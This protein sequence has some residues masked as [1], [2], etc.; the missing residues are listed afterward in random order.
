MADKLR[1]LTP[2]DV[3]YA[4]GDRPTDQKLEGAEIQTRDAFSYLE[5]TIGDAFGEGLLSDP[6]YVSNISRDIGDRSFLNPVLQPNIEIAGYIQDL[7]AG[8]ME[9]EL[10][11]IPI[12]F[13]A[14]IV[15]SSAD[16]SVLPSQ[17]KNSVSLLEVPGDWT[18]SAG[19]T[20]DGI[21][22][23]SR[24]L[25]THSP[26]NGG[27]I[28]I[29]NVTS[30]RGSGFTKGRNN[31]I[32]S[33]AQARVGGA[34]LSVSVSD[35]TNNIY[36][37]QLPIESTAL[38]HA[39]LDSA[40]SLSNTKPGVGGGQQLKLPTWMFS[41]AGLDMSTSDPVSGRGKVF[42]LNSIRIY[43][44]QTKKIVD[45]LLETKASTNVGARETEI[46]CT[47][48]SDVILDDLSGQYILVTSGASLSECI[49]ALQRDLYFHKHM[50]DDMIRGINHADL[51]DL[52]T[53]DV[54]L[55]RS[56]YYG[57]SSIDNNHHSMYLHRGGFDSLDVGA[58]GNIFRGD[59]L[60]GSDSTG[61]A[62]SHENY[63]LDTDSFHLTFGTETNGGRIYFDKI[64]VQNLPE[65]RGNIPQTFS[66]TS[67]VIEGAMDS[68]GLI[69]TTYIDGKLRAGSDV[70][71][72]TDAT[73]DVLIPGDLY[74]HNS[75]IL[76]PR[77]TSG[78]T[79]ETG[80][81]IYSSDENAPIF[82]NGSRW[83]NATSVGYEV[84]LGDGT[85]SHGKYS[86]PDLATFQAAIDDVS[87]NGGGKLKV[88][89]GNYNFGTG[90]ANIPSQVEVEG[91]G[92]LSFISSST[93]TFSFNGGSS[94]SSISQMRI[95]G[96][97]IAISID[98]N[99]HSVN[100]V[101]LENSGTG[102][103]IASSA[104]ETEL[105]SSIRYA[106]I[107]Q[108]IN[109]LSTNISNK[110]AV[111]KTI[112]YQNPFSPIDMVDKASMI[113]KWKRTSGGGT[114]SYV[115]TTN[116]VMG[117]GVFRISGT[118][119]FV[120]E[121]YIPAFPLAGVGGYVGAYT[122]G[123]AGVTIGYQAYDANLSLLS[124][125]GG[126]ILNGGSLTGSWQF[127]QDVS[128]QESGSGANTFPWGTRFIRASVTVNYNSNHVYFDGLTI[129]PLTFSTISLYA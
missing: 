50:G 12:G 9:H 27:S 88:L 126:F 49:G 82:W 91:E 76:S 94:N 63:N 55:D 129:V 25:I 26:S 110:M 66:D 21:Q 48:R 43:D 22:K 106:N 5:N 102:I 117:R 68:S 127:F 3:T 71:L 86:A 62:S 13:G 78:L 14:S 17:F 65:G 64:R 34:F 19:I 70:V 31:T 87:A 105:G 53:G 45:G 95:L 124:S 47:F 89:K 59:L 93:V 11:L 74:I 54:G 10:D 121:D 40:S 118:G 77:T 104:T 32:P 1:D 115:D 28:T 56:K 42:P 79:P 72:G 4:P 84:V 46:I 6:V 67:I 51:I 52:R 44:W 57:P 101:D 61:Q 120:F 107:S 73:H 85:V 20:E 80:M 36:T 29:A 92:N 113:S 112:G 24:K 128:V 114:I 98:G 122:D 69:N 41:P 8:K 103:K 83:L 23:N 123:S 18:I 15:S 16:S 108:Q 119:T 35:A 39:Y 37:I 90:T 58:G 111:S 97:S 100:D 96:S 2:I 60:I 109:Y 7:T 30:G 38:S 116:T 125:H 75:L 81:S 33:I 99:N